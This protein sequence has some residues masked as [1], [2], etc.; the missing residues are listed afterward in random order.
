MFST[1]SPYAS[2]RFIFCYIMQLC[3]KHVTYC[4]VTQGYQVP[5]G[6]AVIYAIRDT[7]EMSSY[8]ENPSEFNPDRW[9]NLSI[10]NNQF[11]YLPFG[12]GRRACAGKDL[13][14]LMLKV[15][16]LEIVRGCEWTLEKDNP[17]FVTF[18]VPYPKDGMPLVFRSTTKIV[19]S[20]TGDSQ[21]GHN[22][23]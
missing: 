20:Q 11:S 22:I 21:T 4:F 13:A 18:P 10:K 5:K 1:K 23:V 16:V 2:V 7:H 3:F 8:F 17:E 6:W 9:E 14:R 19:D 12:G 15:F